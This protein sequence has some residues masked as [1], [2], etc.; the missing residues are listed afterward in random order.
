MGG[1]KDVV[2]TGECFLA[3]LPEE[4]I[5]E[6]GY[7]EQVLRF[8]GSTGKPAFVDGIELQPRSGA[9]I[10]VEF[11]SYAAGPNKGKQWITITGTE[12]MYFESVHLRHEAEAPG[13]AENH[14]ELTIAEAEP[15]RYTGYIDHYG[16]VGVYHTPADAEYNGM[17][18][19]L[20]GVPRFHEGK[21]EIPMYAKL[22]QELG[23]SQVEK[24][25]T[26]TN[27]SLEEAVAA[28]PAKSASNEDKCETVL[29]G[30][31][32]TS[33]KATSFSF[34]TALLDGHAVTLKNLNVVVDGPKHFIVKAGISFPYIPGNGSAAGTSQI[35]GR[36]LPGEESKQ[37]GAFQALVE[38]EPA[39]SFRFACA[40]VSFSTPGAPLGPYPIYLQQAELGLLHAQN[41]WTAS[42]SVKLKAGTPISAPFLGELTQPFEA[43]GTA[44]VEI[45]GEGSTEPWGFGFEGDTKFLG[46]TVS[47]GSLRYWSVPYGEVEYGV[48]VI[49]IT[50]AL[51]LNNLSVKG[52]FGT[53]PEGKFGFN[54]VGHVD[55]DADMFKF[56]EGELAV[57]DVGIGACGGIV[58]GHGEAKYKW[59]ESSPDLSIGYGGCGG[60]LSD[61]E[62]SFYPRCQALEEA[63]AKPLSPN[64]YIGEAMATVQKLLLETHECIEAPTIPLAAHERR[65]AGG[66]HAAGAIRSKRP[67]SIVG[68]KPLEAGE[69]TAT[70]LVTGLS[71]ANIVVTGT[72]RAPVVTVYGP[73]G[74]EF[75]TVLVPAI[76]AKLTGQSSGYQDEALKQTVIALNKPAGG[77]YVIKVDAGSSP[78]SNVEHQDEQ[79]AP[80]ITASVAKEGRPGGRRS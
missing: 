26:V 9:G 70:E 1:N 43:D 74:E 15:G 36:K 48:S 20:F 40:Q 32:P 6:H 51:T 18:I 66:L 10:N 31:L 72:E 13:P 12:D 16:A 19:T 7:P 22:P 78:V 71:A 3:G 25:T 50:G 62:Q 34:P 53:D 35:E 44:T 68:G 56:G 63:L 37:T 59:G 69:S 76:S 30:P 65:V 38:L 27:G 28:A 80:A 4:H 2:I 67:L 58:G 24:P 79:P 21:A 64:D 11:K 47:H 75:Q 57:S 17:P 49:P 29:S 33:P 73:D 61:V 60:E 46:Q 41:I 52:Q 5:E 39:P 77:I 14:G 54:V 23:G 55:A 8:R 45:P 42:A